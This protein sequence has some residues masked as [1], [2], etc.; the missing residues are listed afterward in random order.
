MT[1]MPRLD[2]RG[3]T[4]LELLMS[5]LLLGTALMGLA[6]SFPYAMSGVV[7]GG[8]QTSATLL[9]QE[10]IEVAKSMP[11][12]RLPPD[13][14]ANC[15]ASPAGFPG[16]TRSVAIATGTPTA[17]TTTVTVTVNFNDRQGVNSTVIATVFS[18]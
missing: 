3:V 17:T 8:F 16:M 7:A 18:Q 14:P 5:M 13:L 11:Y 15:P 1:T 2:E 6:A 4:L 9:A 12:D 10:C